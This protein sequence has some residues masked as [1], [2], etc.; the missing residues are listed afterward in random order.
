MGD[1]GSLA[2]GGALAGLA[3]LTKSELVLI[4]LGGVYVIEALS[5]IIQVISFQ[6]RGKRIFRMSPLHH[7]FELAGWSERKVVRVFWFAA[8]VFAILG[9]SA[10]SRMIA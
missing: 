9:V 10:F 7:H 2:L 1:C 4:V 6:T 8:A 3:I 5:V